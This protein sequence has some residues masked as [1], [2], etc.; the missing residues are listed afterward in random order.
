M[1]APQQPAPSA[2]VFGL[3]LV[4]VEPTDQMVQA[5]HHIDLSYMPGQE[6]ADRAA[7]YRAM[8]AAAPQPAVQQWN[9]LIGKETHAD[10]D[11]LLVWRDEVDFAIPTPQADSQPAPVLDRARIREIFMAHGFTVKEG[12]TDLKQYVYD[13]A[14]ALLRAARAP[15]DSVTA[16]AGPGWQWVPIDPTNEMLDAARRA[17]EG[18]MYPQDMRHGP[19]AMMADRYNAMLAAAP[20]P[21]AQ[22]ADS[23][24]EDADPIRALIAEHAAIL[25]QNESAYFELCYHRATG[26]MAWITDKP[27]C[28]PPVVN[29]DRNVLAQG[30]GDTADEACRDAARKQGGAT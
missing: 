15:A 11:G 1:E 20:T 3:R 8:I 28:M 12:Q 29:P 17:C 19:R 16:P 23:V 6:G 27:L 7:I 14:D 9:D 25:D 24:L 4:P 21:P 26:W 2:A 18:R 5:A 30:Q 10:A 22:A 13:A